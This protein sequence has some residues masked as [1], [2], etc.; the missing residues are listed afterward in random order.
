MIA[1]K[2]ENGDFI[3]LD[4]VTQYTQT[5]T[6]QISQH[7]VDGSG[8]VSDHVIKQNPKIQIVAQITGADFNY[9]KPDLT[10][11]D[12]NFIGVNQVV[13]STDRASLVEVSYENNA[14][15]L[16]PD[17]AGQFFSDS[18]PEVQNLSEGRDASYSEKI[19]FEILKTFYKEKSK[20][21]VYEFDNG[22]VDSNPTDNVFITNLS[23]N[24]SAENGDGLLLNITLEQVTISNLLETEIPEDVREDF[25]KKD[26]QKSN[27]GGVGST[28]VTGTPQEVNTGSG[29]SALL[30]I[31]G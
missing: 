23:R 11:E 12:R 14:F 7:P 24:E 28:D 27:K 9:S 16:L 22:G 6:S 5:F 29:L 25:Q 26:A 21:T 15:N 18:I 13:V 20:L 17:V 8:V 2:N 4:V 30:G 3:Y 1:L 10:A 31:S 19:L